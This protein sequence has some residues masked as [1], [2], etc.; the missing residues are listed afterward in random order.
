[1]RKSKDV[2]VPEAWAARDAG[3]VFRITEW[4]AGRAEKWGARMLLTLRGS[5]ANIPISVSHLTMSQVAAVGI[6][7]F[8]QSAV[9]PD[10]LI[11]LLD[12]LLECVQII[13][14]PVRHPDVATAIV[15]D[16]DI[17]EIRTRLWLRSEVIELH[18]G[19]S[20]ADALSD[21]IHWTSAQSRDQETSARS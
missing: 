11:P 7:A 6:N 3:K 4:P 17:Q 20:A 9:M 14:D 5:G 1:M 15:G 2:T 13:R 12:E 8:F 19:F 16:E 18:T 21:L 10:E